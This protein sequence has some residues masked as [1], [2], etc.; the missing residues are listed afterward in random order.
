M[1][2][3]V[4][5]SL[6]GVCGT[7]L[8][9]GTYVGIALVSGAPLHEVPLISMFV[10]PPEEPEGLSEDEVD[11]ANEKTPRED[12]TGNDLLNA[13]A[14]LLGAFLM[15]PPFSPK[16]LRELENELKRKLQQ[17]SIEVENLRL[18]KLEL[19]EWQSSIRDREAELSD[20]RT[21]LEAL[22][23]KINLGLSELEYNQ[24]VEQ[25][26]VEEGWRRLAEMYK[27][28]E[29]RVA[30]EMLQA[31]DPVDGALILMELNNKVASD[32]LREVTPASERK[33]YMD[34]YR[35]ATPKKE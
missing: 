31:E 11:L 30:A 29:P 15:E 4:K 21:K 16:G 14:G 25:E 7:A 32:I 33:K 9:L 1:N 17:Q 22:E 24:A 5:Y 23:S 34:A 12:R 35:L 27:G 19:D 3:I 13:N 28:S 10:G 6:F 26:N 2:K 20:R 8:F 18:R